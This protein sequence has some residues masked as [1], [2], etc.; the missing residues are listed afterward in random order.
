MNYYKENKIKR[1]HQFDIIVAGDYTIVNSCKGQIS[2]N[3]VTGIFFEKTDKKNISG[4]FVF[5]GKYAIS[6]SYLQ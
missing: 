2:F 6:S 3:D 5:D 1:I 4:S